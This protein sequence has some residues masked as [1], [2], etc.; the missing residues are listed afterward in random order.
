MCAF[1]SRPAIKNCFISLSDSAPNSR[2][3]LLKL[4]FVSLSLSLSFVHLLIT[5]DTKESR[6]S[7]FFFLLE[8]PKRHPFFFFL[9]GAAAGVLRAV[10]GAFLG[11]AQALVACFAVRAKKE[12]TPREQSESGV[13][14]TGDKK[15]RGG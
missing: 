4:F 10:F 1:T 2:R 15:T 7:V 14:T 13:R 6:V 3:V 9:L 11:W 8:T 5:P 12:Q